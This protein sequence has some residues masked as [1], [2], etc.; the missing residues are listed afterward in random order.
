M[1]SE[2]ENVSL[3]IPLLIQNYPGHNNTTTTT[4]QHNNSA[5]QHQYQH[6]NTNVTTQQQYNTIQRQ[7]NNTT[8][9]QYN[10]TTTQYRH[11]NAAT[12]QHDSTTKEPANHA[13]RHRLP[14]RFLKNT[15]GTR[16]LQM[17]NTFSLLNK[18][19]FFQP[20]VASA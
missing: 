12:Q 19:P 10:N 5:I 14:Q 3:T 1:N 17:T 20:Q 18:S 2:F 7:H 4:Q 13:E 15:P 6:N 8:T 9:I 16:S 11:N